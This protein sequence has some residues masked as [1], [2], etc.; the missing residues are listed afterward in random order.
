MCHEADLGS[1]GAEG[2]AWYAYM[3]HGAPN[4][5]AVMWA[6]TANTAAELFRC[7]GTAT[8]VSANALASAQLA[9]SGGETQT[10]EA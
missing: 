2:G 6:Q 8:G 3:A 4:W 9:E 1:L 7:G 10:V 5:I